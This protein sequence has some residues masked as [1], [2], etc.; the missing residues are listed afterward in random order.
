M[1][2]DISS[3][4][5]KPFYRRVIASPEDYD[6]L[7][8]QCEVIG[9]FNP[10]A[11]MIKN[12]GKLETLLMVRVTE[13]PIINLTNLYKNKVFLPYFRIL[14]KVR[15]K[16]EMGFDEISYNEIL[17]EGK[18][19]V[20]LKDGTARLKHISLPRFLR[21][22]KE[23]NMLDKQQNPALYP[24]FEYERFGMEDF[25][26]TPFEDG[27]FILTY[28]SPHRDF[29]VSTP[30]LITRDFKEYKH[31]PE[32]NTPRPIM[33]GI[34]DV[35]VFP[36]KLPS[37]SK[38][39]IINKY[40]KIYSGFIRPNSFYEVSKPGIWISY[41][42]DLIHWGQNH[43]LTMSKNGEVS[44]SGT[45]AIKVKDCWVSAY[46]ETTKN[47][48][49]EYVYKTKLMKINYNES[50]KDFKSS[51][52]LLDREDYLN[53]LPESGYVPNIVF[54]SGIT[55]NEGIITLYS[56]IDDTWTVMDKFYEEDLVKFLGM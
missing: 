17:S 51:N 15:T 31:F 22:D 50:W 12:K 19:E 47:F 24:A 25:R 35:I 49:G 4:R 8:N 23:G 27:R 48:K 52:V 7:S 9:A 2:D 44:G 32:D 40:Q 56:G 29:G 21:L 43:R 5:P 3:S 34:K 28:V 11:V 45:P 10:G 13:S 6:S 54:T 36:E 20:F 1:K 33:T 55:N 37:P 30:F 41:S 53:I 14:N 26:I 46:H 39:E 38:T 18:K 42:P 16:L